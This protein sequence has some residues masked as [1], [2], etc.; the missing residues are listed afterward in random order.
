AEQVPGDTH[1]NLQVDADYSQQTFKHVLLPLWLL[2]YQYGAKTFRI[3]CNGFTG[4]VAGKYPKSWLKVT[5]LVIFIL[6]VMAIIFVFA[7]GS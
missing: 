4:T 3:V 2:T 1:W 7:E 6:I 5:L